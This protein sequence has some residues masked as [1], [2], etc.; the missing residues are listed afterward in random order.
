MLIAILSN[1]FQELIHAIEI[2]MRC[3]SIYRLVLDQISPF[4]FERRLAI[5]KIL[6][7]SLIKIAIRGKIIILALLN[8]IIYGIT[9]FFLIY[10]YI[11]IV[12][13]RVRARTQAR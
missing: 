9:V 3:N 10:I 1:V 12:C 7:G 2:L 5:L 13:A 11:V 8:V 6:E 4:I